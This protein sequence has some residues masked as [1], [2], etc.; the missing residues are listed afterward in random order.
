[1]ASGE[2]SLIVR[3]VDGASKG[4]R[5]ISKQVKGMSD[6]FFA[7]KGAIAGFQATFG[8]AIDFLKSSVQAWSE[9]ESAVAK[10]N[11]SMKS[12]GTFSEEASRGLQEY[13]GQLQRT[14]NFAD[15]NLISSMALASSYGFTAS[16][17][18]GLTQAA[19]DLAVKFGIDLNTATLMVAKA[20]NGSTDQLGRFGIR[21]RETNDPAQRFADTLAAVSGAAGGAAAAQLDTYAG[22]VQQLGLRWGEVKETVGGALIPPLVKVLDLTLQAFDAASRLYQAWSGLPNVVRAVTS[23]LSAISQGT[24][25]L[26][27]LFGAGDEEKGMKD[28]LN[29]RQQFN[30]ANFGMMEEENAKFAELKKAEVDQYFMTEEEKNLLKAE[31][32]AER[33]RQIGE[34]QLAED[35]ITQAKAENQVSINAK[36]EE[37]KQRATQQRVAVTRNLL[38]GFAQFQNA[39]SKEVAAVAKGAAIAETLMSTYAMA[40]EAYRSMVKVPFVG[41]A[42]GA[43]A[44]AAAMAMGLANVAA[45]KGVQLATGGVVMPRS[46]GVQATI[47][48]AG[49]PEAVIPLGDSRAT[50]QLRETLGGGITIN[51]Y[52]QYADRAAFSEFVDKIDE[53]LFRR[54]R[55][56]K[57]FS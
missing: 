3:L 5:D 20:A 23:P 37:E 36:E 49:Q 2:A 48:E 17:V 41:P 30:K 15:E 1:M 45:I 53:E 46:G 25:K 33:L 11:Q 26:K 54:G 12:A 4:L 42:L 51:L 40:T 56:G 24:Q 8:V 31:K 14:T 39:K 7:A 57:S 32:D 13:A 16:Q 47:A 29:Q 19:A 28:A 18:K 44:A 34:N 50:D 21:L 27:S 38:N 9:Q 10:L 22:K 43:A 6:L 35:L 52:A 55:N